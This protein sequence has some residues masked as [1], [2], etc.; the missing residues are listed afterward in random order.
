MNECNCYFCQNKSEFLMNH[1][2]FK[3]IVCQKCGKYIL[4]QSLVLDIYQKNKILDKFRIFLVHNQKENNVIFFGSSD[5]FNNYKN[6]EPNSTAILY[7]YD[8]VMNWF[9]KNFNDK[10][11]KILYSLN[12]FS[13]FEG[14]HISLSNI[15]KYDLFFCD[16]NYDSKEIQFEFIKEY[17]I[18]NKYISFCGE[19]IVLLPDGFK[20]VYDYVKNDFK[21]AFVAMKFG[22]ETRSIRE[23][24]RKGICDAGYTPIFIDE[25]IHN[26]QIVP[27]MLDEIKKS[28]FLVMDCTYNNCG[29]YYEAGIALGL[30]KEVI[31]TCNNNISECK[32]QKPHFDI[33]QKQI[34]FW[35]DEDFLSS[36]LTR[37][38]RAVIN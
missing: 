11:D 20:V 26:H 15:D 6:K 3:I 18:R 31:I 19:D 1:D 27:T 5:E 9:P 21:T 17:M 23:A 33:A 35:D 16:S 4:S 37:W 38:I 22:E 14:A 34:L 2:P 13:I 25:K 7:T 10:I 28:K 32:D 30:G 29:A 36:N 12:K 8:E 24:L